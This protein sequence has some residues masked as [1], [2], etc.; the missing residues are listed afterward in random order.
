MK[1]YK[2]MLNG[3]NFKLNLG[4][5]FARHGF[6]TTRYANATSKS[7]AEHIAVE[8]IRKRDDINLRLKNEKIDPPIIYAEEIVEIDSIDES[9]AEPDLTWFKEE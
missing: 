7:A 4:E 9:A 5:G 1:K 6:Y 2:I 3:Q 8:S